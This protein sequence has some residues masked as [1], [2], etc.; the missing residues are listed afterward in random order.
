MCVNRSDSCP[1][2]FAVIALLSNYIEMHLDRYSIRTSLF[3]Y[4]YTSVAYG[5]FL[6]CSKETSIHH[7]NL[8]SMA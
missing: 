6:R 7:L 2:T 1:F 8:F 4:H 3:C 5:T